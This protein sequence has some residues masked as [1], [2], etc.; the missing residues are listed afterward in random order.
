MYTNRDM[1]T[2]LLGAVVALVVAYLVFGPTEE[3][4]KEGCSCR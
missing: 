2:A 1:R 4:K 3:K